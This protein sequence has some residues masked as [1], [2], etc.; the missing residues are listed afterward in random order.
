VYDEDYYLLS[1]SL[2]LSLSLC[3]AVS[4]IPLDMCW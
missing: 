2:S 3:N 4:T 1:L